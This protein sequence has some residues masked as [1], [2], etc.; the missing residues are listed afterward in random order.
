MLQICYVERCHNVTIF[1]TLCKVTDLYIDDYFQSVTSSQRF[2]NMLVSSCITNDFRVSF[3]IQISNKAMTEIWKQVVLRQIFF[4]AASVVFICLDWIWVWY[5]SK[6]NNDS[7][8]KLDLHRTIVS[9]CIRV[10]SRWG[11]RFCR[12]ISRGFLN[13]SNGLPSHRQQRFGH[14]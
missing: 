4:S 9:V 11:R 2:F 5:G 3:M 7:T 12:L 8:R 10:S 6:L 14:R 1:I 13:W